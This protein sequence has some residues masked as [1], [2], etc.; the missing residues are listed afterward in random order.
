MAK[1]GRICV[2]IGLIITAIAFI[3]GFGLMFYGGYDALVKILLMIV[4]VG[5][6][7]L[8]TGV[9]TVTLFAPRESDRK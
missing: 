8:F 5:F 2:I 4:P 3:A 6:L 9:A 1:L 7:I